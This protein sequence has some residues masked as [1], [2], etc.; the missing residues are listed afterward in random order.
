MPV[1]GL[2]TTL[3]KMSTHTRVGFNGQ[4]VLRGWASSY[5]DYILADGLALPVP[6][7]KHRRNPTHTFSLRRPTHGKTVPSVSQIQRRGLHLPFPV[8]WSQCVC[9]KVTIFQVSQLRKRG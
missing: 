9:G 4:K 3:T 8:I 6:H 1:V 7:S 5:V 2:L